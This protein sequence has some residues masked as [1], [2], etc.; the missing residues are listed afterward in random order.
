MKKFKRTA[1]LL[2]TLSMLGSAVVGCGN[3][4]EKATNGTGSTSSTTESTTGTT[5]EA[6]GP[7]QISMMTFDFEGSPLSG[8][9]G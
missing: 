9:Y 4:E 7:A 2:L 3:S 5:T 6:T 1:A 8:D